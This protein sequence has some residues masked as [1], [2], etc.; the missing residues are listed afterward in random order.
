MGFVNFLVACSSLWL[1]LLN[2]VQ[3]SWYNINIWHVLFTDKVYNG[4]R[5]GCGNPYRLQEKK[6]QVEQC[7]ESE[8]NGVKST[9]CFCATSYCNAAVSATV[10]LT[11]LILLLGCMFVTTL[12]PEY[13]SEIKKTHQYI[14]Q[15]VFIQFLHFKYCLAIYLSL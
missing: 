7:I 8:N 10:S 6:I 14:Y 2:R 11:S 9:E 12:W 3:F 15:R 5:R 13:V 4:V 1:K